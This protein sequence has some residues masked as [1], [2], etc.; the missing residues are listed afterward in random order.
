VLEQARDDMLKVQARLFKTDVGPFTQG[1]EEEII[2][3]LKEVIEA[4]KRAQQELKDQ[5][6]QPPPPPPPGGQPG[7]RSLINILQELRMIRSLQVR[8]NTRTT[9]Y[10]KQYPGE[11][12]DEPDIQ[13]ELHNLAQRQ[14]KIQKATKDIATGK[15]GGAQQ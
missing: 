15:A 10:G 7:P 3:M 1:I 9:A 12:A 2:S 11:Q 4:L 14:D 5:K 6:D 8:V 13:K